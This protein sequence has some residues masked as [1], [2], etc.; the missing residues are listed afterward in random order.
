MA[1]HTEP[2][3]IGRHPCTRLGTAHR[4]PSIARQRCHAGPATR[5][6]LA[7]RVPSHAR[8]WSVPPSGAASM[9]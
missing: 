3:P 2:A 8:R 1:E 9:V 6:A 5:S 4:L 7:R